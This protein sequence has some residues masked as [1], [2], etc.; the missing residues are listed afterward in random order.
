MTFKPR[1]TRRDHFLVSAGGSLET[2]N[3][4]VRKKESEKRGCAPVV[5]RSALKFL[6]RMRCRRVKEATTFLSRA[7]YSH[8]SLHRARARF[9]SRVSSPAV[10]GSCARRTHRGVV[11]CSCVWDFSVSACAGG[12]LLSSVTTPFFCFLA[13]QP[14]TESPA[15]RRGQ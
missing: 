2:G 9:E 10:A 3:S 13:R 5:G 14:L 12:W 6:P 8:L 11:S 1:D 4:P 15:S 7:F